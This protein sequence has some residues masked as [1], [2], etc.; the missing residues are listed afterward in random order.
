MPY[1]N[2]GGGDPGGWGGSRG[3]SSTKVMNLG[4]RCSACCGRT[5]TNPAEVFPRAVDD[6]YK[7]ATNGSLVISSSKFGI[8]SNDED[9]QGA[10]SSAVTLRDGSDL[11]ITSFVSNEDWSCQRRCD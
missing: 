4:G 8:T 2:W 11:L 7:V 5:V 9:P 6:V 1:G 3:V 10:T